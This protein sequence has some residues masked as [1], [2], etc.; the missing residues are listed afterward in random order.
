[1]AWTAGT[2]GDYVRSSGTYAS[3]LTDREWVLIAPHLPAARTGG[4]PRSTCLRRVVN[5][6]FPR[7]PA[8]QH[9]LRLLP[10]LD[11]R[12]GLGASP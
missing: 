12:R 6:V 2:R 11:R 8:A 9:G 3:D 10:D 4:R 7:F 5:A 1:M